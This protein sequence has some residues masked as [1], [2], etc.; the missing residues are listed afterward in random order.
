M[1]DFYPVRLGIYFFL[2]SGFLFGVSERITVAVLMPDAIS[3]GLAF[4]SS[5]CFALLLFLKP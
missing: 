2:V 4:V 3:L 5:G 1:I